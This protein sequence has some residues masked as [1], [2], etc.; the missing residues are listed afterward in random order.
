MSQFYTYLH[1]KPNGEPFYVGKGSG[2][3][4]REFKAARNEHHRNTVA[5]YGAG[6]ILVFKFECESED[7]SLR[8]EIQHIA[9]LRKEG[10]SLVNQTDG[11]EGVSGYK[12]TLEQSKHI[13]SVRKGRPAKNKGGTVSQEVRDKISKTLTG[14]KPTLETIAKLKSAR[15]KRIFTPETCAKIADGQRA[16]HA[17]NKLE[18]GIQ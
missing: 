18:K 4:F 14:R 13:S 16:R 8:D 3:R 5:K 6:N 12:Y 1:C 7:Q 11:G 10:F 15:A 2:I 9:Q 17:R